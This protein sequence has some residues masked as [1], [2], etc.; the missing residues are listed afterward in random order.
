MEWT[1]VAYGVTAAIIA[2]LLAIAEFSVP[3]TSGLH[4]GI[5]VTSGGT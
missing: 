5:L 3:R 4:S 2:G 1:R